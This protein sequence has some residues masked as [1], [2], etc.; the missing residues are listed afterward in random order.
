MQME[1]M[2]VELTEDEIEAVAG[3]TRERVLGVMG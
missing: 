3:G 1:E 2:V